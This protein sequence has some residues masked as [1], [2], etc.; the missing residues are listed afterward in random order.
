MS[1]NRGNRIL[2][3]VVGLVLGVALSGLATGCASGSSGE[4]ADAAS[5]GGSDSLVL[6][7]QPWV[8][9][10]VQN[11]ITEQLLERLG[12][13]VDTE[14]VS[15]ELGA[16]SM[17]SG[18][19][20]AFLGN[21]WPSQR[22]TFGRMLQQ[23]DVQVLST[24]LTGTR[25]APA[26]PGDTAQRLGI[27]SLADLDAHADEFGRKI[28][29]IE[30][31]TPGNATVQQ[32]IANDSYGLG[33]WKLVESSTPAMLTQVQRSQR[34]GKPIVFLGW[35]PHWMTVQFDPVFLKDPQ[36]VW[37]GAGEIR[38][39]VRKGYSQE[40]PDITRFLSQ[41]RFTKAEA[42]QFYYAHDKRGESLEEIAGSWIKNNPERVKSFLTGV[43]SADGQPATSVIF[44]K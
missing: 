22:P 8:D 26:V 14:S 10:E 17:Q 20:D 3:R 44:D 34:A 2:T 21:W 28:Y 41:L 1:R 27:T 29:G 4:F 9:L 30:P 7:D 38:T 40:A 42:S 43:K 12:Y 18:Q 19:I 16:K 25:Y 5:S 6:L 37:G 24:L 31:G 32:M 13:S 39:L 33:D 36:D 23:G 11:E 15:V 35:S